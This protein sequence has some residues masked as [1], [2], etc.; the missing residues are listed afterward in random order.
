M[1]Y[2]GA[3]GEEMGKNMRFGHY[4]ASVDG[5]NHLSVASELY[6]GGSSTGDT[7]ATATP[8]LA[9]LLTIDVNHILGAH[10]AFFG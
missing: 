6:C 4:R 2:L 9:P 10:D 8:L 5:H 1:I 7:T 3:V